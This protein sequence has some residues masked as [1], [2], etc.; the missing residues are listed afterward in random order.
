MGSAMC[1]TEAEAFQKTLKVNR[2]I[3]DDPFYAVPPGTADTSAGTLLKLEKETD[4]S[5]YSLAPGLSLSRFMYQSKT[6]TGALVPVSG[7]ILWPYT[8]RMH[9]GKPAMVVWA[10]GTS[11]AF[12]ECA[13]S[14]THNLWHHFQCPFQLA[15]F[16]Y[17]VIAP[18]YAGLGVG[19]DASGLSI[20]HEYITGPAQANDLFHSIPAAR[21]AFPE[22]SDDF[23]LIG[24]SLGGGAAWSFAEKLVKEP[25]S[26]HLGTAI[27]HPVTRV[28]DMPRDLPIMAFAMMYLAPVLQRYYGLSSPAEVFTE[29]GVE[30]LQILQDRR[31][32]NT[33]AFQLVGPDILKPDWAH[34]PSVRAYQVAAENG[35]KALSRPVLI[36]QGDA[37]PVIHPPTTQAAIDKTMK[38]HPET[39]IEY[40]VLPGVTH[41]SAMYPGQAIYMD[42]IAARF[43][44]TPV[45][46]KGYSKTVVQTVR[47]VG[48]QKVEADWHIMKQEHPWELV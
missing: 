37:D 39:Q 32:F 44:G 16:G 14:N 13:P 36:I 9:K 2:S 25:I 23:V 31:G 24:S 47:P 35:G 4:I 46:Q 26:G 5:K 40:Y 1:I 20:L 22:L 33:L 17:T 48:L 30:H 3:S 43:E 6:S 38:N 7:C 45:K 19:T 21:S 12:P 8:A 15:L 28:I 29:K 18:D 34:H 42:W 10:H 11:G 27:I 41:A